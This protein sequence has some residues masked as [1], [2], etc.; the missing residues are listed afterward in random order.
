[1]WLRNATSR[2]MAAHLVVVALSTAM[3]LAFVYYQT[4]QVIEDEVREIVTADLSGLG[5]DY[6]EGGTLGLAR[7]IERRLADRRRQDAVYLLADA[8]GNRI[9]GNLAAWPPV[10][11]PTS[12]WVE[13]E[14]YRSDRDRVTTL[15]V[16]A[17]PL[18]SGD[19]LLVGHDSQAQAKFR[20][21]LLGALGWAL[22]AAGLL[23]LASGWLLSRLVGRRV[24]DVVETA[25]EIVQGDMARRVP[26]RGGGGGRGGDE[27]DRLAETL[28]RMLDRIQGLVGDLRMV[29]DGVAHDLRSPLT[30]LR[31]HLDGSLEDGIDPA[32]RRER[33]ERAIAEADGVLR[34]FTALLQIARTEAGMGRDQFEPIELGALAADVV[35][36]YTPS[37]AEKS[38]RLLQRGEGATVSGHPQLLAN[39]VANLV[40]NA[41]AHAPAGSV[42]GI[43]LSSGPQPTLTVADRGPGIPP[44]ERARVLE[45]FVRLDASRGRP[46]AG[47]GLSLVAAVARLHDARLELDDNGPGLRATIRFGAARIAENTG[48]T[49]NEREFIAATQGRKPADIGWSRGRKAAATEAR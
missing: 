41:I 13:L 21:T 16:A 3:V 46:G 20:R 11:P 9:A 5:D 42:I 33:I 48:G 36:L 25:N 4:R 14:L 8:Q 47:L 19:R 40:E 39:A 18:P 10:I 7:A 31:A 35:D 29:T 15:S 24:A 49:A 27:F 44:D 43:E 22:A 1:M 37:A 38:I 23:A 2:L 45:R 28:N 32:A 26:V 34:A 12:G 17:I 30:R 6:R